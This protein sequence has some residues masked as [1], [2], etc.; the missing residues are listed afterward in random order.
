[1][2]GLEFGS[3][4]EDTATGPTPIDGAAPNRYDRTD[5]ILTDTARLEKAL[6]R[7]LKSQKNVHPATR[8]RAMALRYL[9]AKLEGLRFD[10]LSGVVGT[11]SK[12]FSAYLHATQ[13]VPK[14][15]DERIELLAELL[16]NLH[17]VLE[18]SATGDWFRTP[19]PALGDVT[20]IEALHNKNRLHEVVAITRSYLDT[21][22]T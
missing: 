9:A 17:R 8:E 22:Y 1:M 16:R 2:R 4:D 5:S 14:V 18:P 19:I 12:R 20:P 15:M 6:T 11:S 7:A 21:D 3:A 13:T 10:E